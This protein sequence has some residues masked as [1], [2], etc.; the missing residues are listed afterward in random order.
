MG[1]T[2]WASLVPRRVDSVSGQTSQGHTDGNN[3]TED[4]EFTKAI[5]QSGHISHALDGKDQHEGAD[6]FA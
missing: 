5:R 6:G 3:D 2:A 4:D 1:S